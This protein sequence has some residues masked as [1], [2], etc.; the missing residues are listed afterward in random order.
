[1]PRFKIEVF[2]TLEDP[3]GEHVETR[4]VFAF[5]WI[6]ALAKVAKELIVHEWQP[7]NYFT[8]RSMYGGRFIYQ[9]EKQ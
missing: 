4:T 7:E 8:Y 9:V 2:D 3:K 6:T 5:D 1:M